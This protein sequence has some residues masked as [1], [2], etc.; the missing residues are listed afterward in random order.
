MQPIIL[1]VFL[2]IVL[3]VVVIQSKLIQSWVAQAAQLRSTAEQFA[4][5][6]AALTATAEGMERL[7]ALVN[8]LE[9][10]CKAECEKNDVLAKAV[11]AL[12]ASVLSG[13]SSGYQEYAEQDQPQRQ[14]RLEVHDLLR[15]GIPRKEAEARTRERRI[16][17]SVGRR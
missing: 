7:P 10:L 1:Y 2:S 6:T 17:E 15:Q 12:E 8:G 13:D 9:A 14:E 11:A 4:K 3:V 5:F 16:Y